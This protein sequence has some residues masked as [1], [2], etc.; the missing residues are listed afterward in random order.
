VTTILAIVVVVSMAASGQGPGPPEADPLSAGVAAGRRRL[1]VD[2]LDEALALRR[3]LLE[4]DAGGAR[5]VDR[6]AGLIV[7]F[8]RRAAPLVDDPGLD[9]FADLTPAAIVARMEGA[10]RAV[11]ARG[12]F[13][14]FAGRWFGRW[15]EADVD[16][17]W[18]EVHVHAGRPSPPGLAPVRLLATQPAW[19]GDGFGWNVVAEEPSVGATF[20]LGSVYHVEG[21]DP[22]RVRLH[23]PHV[24]VDS[25]PGRLIWITAGEAFLEEHVPEA[26]GRAER[27]AITGFRHR[28]LNDPRSGIGE[29]F[30]AVYSRRADDRAPWR[31]LALEDS[32]R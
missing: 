32:A 27:Y 19:V 10:G 16:H 13:G 12:V 2:G 7:E 25:G 24:G 5:P 29:A 18:G 8:R 14:P 9:A 30:R 20:L 28:V 3:R 4:P 11:D 6:L 21:G 26:A 15:E 23:R 31:R 22:A 17:D 1:Y